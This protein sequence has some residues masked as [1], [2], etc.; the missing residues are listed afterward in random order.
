MNRSIE[1]I[2]KELSKQSSVQSNVVTYKLYLVEVKHDNYVH[3]LILNN[4]S[5]ILTDGNICTFLNMLF[6]V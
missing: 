1:T 3:I 4:N 6:S 2:F 5:R